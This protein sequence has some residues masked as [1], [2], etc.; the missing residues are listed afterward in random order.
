MDEDDFLDIDWNEFLGAGRNTYCIV[1]THSEIDSTLDIQ[2][3]GT[4]IIDMSIET[5]YDN[6]MNNDENDND[7]DNNKQFLYPLLTQS[8]LHFNTNLL[9]TFPID[10]IPDF[11]FF[12]LNHGQ[13]S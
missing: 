13:C 5:T 9:F 3:E 7:N 4:E 6:D 1:P 10:N 12:F 2:L 11:D 8:N